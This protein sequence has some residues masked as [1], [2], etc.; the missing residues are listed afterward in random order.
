M[1][2]RLRYLTT[3]FLL[4]LTPLFSTPRLHIC[5]TAS[6][7][8]PGV[9]KLLASSNAN[10][11]TVSILGMG[12]P[13][14][15]EK[16]IRDFHKFL[17]DLPDG[18]VALFIDAYDIL[19]L[20]NEETILERFFSFEAPIVFSGDKTCYPFP[21]ISSHYP[22][23]KTRFRYLNSGAYIGYVKDL[24]EVLSE[25]SPIPQKTDDQG[26]YALYH[27]YHPERFVIDTNA[28]LFLTLCI[29]QEDMYVDPF[30]RSVKCLLTHTTPCVAHGNGEGGRIVLDVIYE[31]LFA[32]KTD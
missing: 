30:E 7:W 16:K 14:S 12:E 22:P 8:D 31:K 32:Q 23:C 26:L 19:L 28:E 13:F 3:L 1:T 5:T 18:D 24:K 4:L 2:K 17:S 29:E 10:N 25:M 6:D 9:D 27:L 20:S 11:L 15:L 21:Q